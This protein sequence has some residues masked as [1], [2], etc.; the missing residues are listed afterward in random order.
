[1][2][3]AR[4]VIIIHNN[5]INRHTQNSVLLVRSIL[6]YNPSFWSPIYNINSR[7]IDGIQ[8]TFLSHRN[9]KLHIHIDFIKYNYLM[10]LRK[11]PRTLRPKIFCR[12]FVFI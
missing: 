2:G 10:Q 11:L 4:V 8:H 7:T 12:Y 1:M 9:Y 5:N 3:Q 6:E